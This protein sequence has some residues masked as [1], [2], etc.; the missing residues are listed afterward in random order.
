MTDF[1]S[2]DLTNLLF[3]S[4]EGKAEIIPIMTDE[5]MP[6]DKNLA[7]P[8][9]LPILPL[10]NAILF[11]GVVLPITVGREQSIRLIREYNKK[12]KIIGTATQKSRKTCHG[13]F[14]FGGDGRP[15]FEDS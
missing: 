4:I 6:V 12:S 5:E 10:K 11:P 14:V 1:N 7:V 8:D 13:R 9:V 2:K 3:D 15:D